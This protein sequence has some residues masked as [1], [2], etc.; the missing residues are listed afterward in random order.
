[1]CYY[2][3]SLFSSP[4][5]GARLFLQSRSTP[6][7]TEARTGTC[8]RCWWH[9][10]RWDGTPGGCVCSKGVLPSSVPALGEL[11]SRP[12]LHKLDR[13]YE[14]PGL[15]L[16]CRFWLGR[17]G[18]ALGLC[19]S[20]SV[21]GHCPP[22][23]MEERGWRRPGLEKAE[24]KPR[25][26]EAECPREAQSAALLPPQLC[27]G[28]VALALCCPSQHHL[29]SQERD[30]GYFRDQYSP[31]ALFSNST[32]SHGAA[33]LLSGRQRQSRVTPFG[34]HHIPTASTEHLLV[35]RPALRKH[36]RARGTCPLV[37]AWWMR[38]GCCLRQCRVPGGHRGTCRQS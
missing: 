6:E 35:P 19:I 25:A 7:D 31:A 29:N 26:A 12:A 28:W 9:W 11:S 24:G 20:S 34:P 8:S 5:R 22:P 17:P 10:G 36:A 13:V 18:I 15:F 33:A 21:L 30:G 2:S 32:P 3:Q 38:E 37:P 14:P 4:R 1:M 27:R 23:P 16:K